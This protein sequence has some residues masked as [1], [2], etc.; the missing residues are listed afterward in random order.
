MARAPRFSH[1]PTSLTPARTSRSWWRCAPSATRWSWSPRSTRAEAPLNLTSWP[2]R[3]PEKR[4]WP[5]WPKGAIW[6]AGVIVIPVIYKCRLKLLELQPRRQAFSILHRRI[7]IT[8]DIRKRIF[9]R[10]LCSKVLKDALLL[11]FFFLASIHEQKMFQIEQEMCKGTKNVE[12]EHKMCKG[13][14]NVKREQKICKGTKNMQRNKKCGKGT[15]NVQMERKM[16][17][18]DF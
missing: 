9:N 12:R 17:L 15:K 10:E 1:C 2:R 18:K 3:W 4:P 7:C 8:I 11:F 14:N 6:W 5:L 13:T 16:F